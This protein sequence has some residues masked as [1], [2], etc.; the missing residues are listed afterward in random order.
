VTEP[1]QN[2]SNSDTAPPE[3]S[4]ARRSS[5]FDKPILWIAA[6]FLVGYPLSIGPIDK[7]VEKEFLPNVVLYYERPLYAL[8]D[9]ST[10]FDRFL[11]WYVSDVWQVDEPLLR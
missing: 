7:L 9:K 8:A 11:H 5:I 4:T 10:A 1:R 3:P 2:F 6:V